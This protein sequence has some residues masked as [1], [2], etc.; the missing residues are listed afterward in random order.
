MERQLLLDT[1]NDY[2]V[3]TVRTDAGGA[4]PSRPMFG[5][6]FSSADYDTLNAWP[7]ETMVFK[8]GNRKGLYHQPWATEEAARVG[9]EYI[10][11]AVAD[12]SLEFG[13]GVQ[14]PSGTPSMTPEEWEA[15]IAPTSWRTQE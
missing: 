15:T 14:G 11:K 12:G 10:K 8:D 6:G 2:E 9:H 3:S 1:V 5:F 7:F 4:T 13:K